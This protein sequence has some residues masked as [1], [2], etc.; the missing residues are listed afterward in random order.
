MFSDNQP[1]CP[2]WGPPGRVHLQVV[3]L[4]ILVGMWPPGREGSA[5][6]LSTPKRPNTQTPMI[7]G[8]GLMPQR[9]LSWAKPVGGSQPSG[10]RHIHLSRPQG[11]M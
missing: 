3:R 4:R 1:L 5:P 11:H 2:W 9:L 8:R 6:V 10:C 7:W